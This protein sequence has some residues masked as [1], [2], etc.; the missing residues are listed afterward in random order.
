MNFKK[1]SKNES[2]ENRKNSS[3]T[4]VEIGKKK[5]L[6]YVGVSVVVC[7]VL[8]TSILTIGFSGKK[9][10]K[11]FSGEPTE[12]SRLDGFCSLDVNDSVFGKNED[13]VIETTSKQNSDTGVTAES[14][15][16]VQNTTSRENKTNTT[17]KYIYGT[18][19]AQISETT[20]I[21]AESG[22]ICEDYP[23]Y[24]SYEEY[25]E[26]VATMN[27]PS[28][29][30]YFDQI[31]ELGSFRNC[32]LDF[33][34]EHGEF[35]SYSYMINV[36]GSGAKNK[37]SLTVRI[38]PLSD[39]VSSENIIGKTAVNS[40]DLRNLKTDASGVY[41]IGGVS[42]R[43][44]RGKLEAIDFVSN[45]VLISIVQPG[46][47]TWEKVK[48]DTDSLLSGFL[49]EDNAIESLTQLKNNISK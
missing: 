47:G 7:I 14:V 2:S 36:S 29:F 23:C 4:N 39:R 38:R 12:S 41:T 44:V 17:K 33:C 11:I 35:G 30:I 28:S 42:Y 15:V 25:K 24:N 18:S 37:V 48:I 16:P 9:D 5:T 26:V 10:P 40:N 20:T 27:L 19:S 43:Y 31:S 3:R 8:F 21:P 45:G 49:K 22:I 1:T 13:T 34:P 32:V 6:L 46:R